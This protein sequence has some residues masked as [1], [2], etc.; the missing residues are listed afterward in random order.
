MT[1]ARHPGTGGGSGANVKSGQIMSFQDGDTESVTFGT[2]FASAPDIVFNLKHSTNVAL[3]TPVL[4]TSS[5]TGFSVYIHKGHGG[6]I[7]TWV[8]HWIATDAG[9]P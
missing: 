7:H 9:D 5:T 3:D 1:E 8:V 2:P 6:S 4:R